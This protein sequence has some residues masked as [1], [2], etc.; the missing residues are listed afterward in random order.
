MRGWTQRVGDQLPLLA[1]TVPRFLLL[2]RVQMMILRMDWHAAVLLMPYLT[3]TP[4]HSCTLIHCPP[5]E[6]SGKALGLPMAAL[7]IVELSLL[8]TIGM[9]RG[10]ARNACFRWPLR[11]VTC[12]SQLPP[13]KCELNL[14][15]L[16]GKTAVN[17]RLDCQLI[18]LG[19]VELVTCGTGEQAMLVARCCQPIV[20]ATR[21]S[22]IP[23]HCRFSTC[24][25]VEPTSRTNFNCCSQCAQMLVQRVLYLLATFAALITLREA[26]RDVT[27]RKQMEAMY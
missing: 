12:C 21:M 3:H 15:A 7:V 13:C 1:T 16:F 26:S 11:C 25:V 20:L 8:A 14:S 10:R 2:P 9:V 5:P 19:M 22:T 27:V 23:R 17:L 6:N 18:L 24:M 4:T